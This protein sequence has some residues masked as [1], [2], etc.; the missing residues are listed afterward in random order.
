MSRGEAGETCHVQ[1][2]LKENV[3]LFRVA[4]V[5]LCDTASHTFHLTLRTFHST[6][7]IHFLEA[8]LYTPHLSS[9]VVGHAS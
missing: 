8:T 1:G 6:F 9:Q 7:Y 5:A 2:V 3:M 4:G